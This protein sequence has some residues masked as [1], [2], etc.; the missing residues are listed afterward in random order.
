MPVPVM[1]IRKMRMTVGE[2]RVFVAMRVR[3][4]Q[5]II[6]RMRMLMMFVMNMAML[7]FQCLMLML[8][9]VPFNQMQIQ[10]DTHKNSGYQKRRGER[11]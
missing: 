11:F 4:S 2:W 1:Q 9:F 8:M 6:L 7:M 10:A 3:L 5:G